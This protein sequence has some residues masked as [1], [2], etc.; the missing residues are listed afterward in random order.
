MCLV[1][2][3]K[4]EQISTRSVIGGLIEEL[5]AVKKENEGLKRELDKLRERQKIELVKV[6]ESQNEIHLQLEE[7]R[8]ESG[9]FGKGEH[10]N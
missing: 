6:L 8:G 10:K 7:S 5:Q 1:R 3:V 2:N 4:L 9:R